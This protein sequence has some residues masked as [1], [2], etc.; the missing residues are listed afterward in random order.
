MTSYHT[1]L[2]KVLS[3]PAVSVT[4]A[5]F[6]DDPEVILGYSVSRQGKEGVVLDWIFVKSAWRR[7]GVGKSLTPANLKFVTHLTKVGK[8]LKPTGVDFNPFA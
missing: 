8:A 4:V 2:E 6:E 1:I 7:I 5:C 3:N